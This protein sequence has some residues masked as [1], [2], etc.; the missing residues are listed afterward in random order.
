MIKKEL[1]NQ[2]TGNKPGLSKKAT[3]LPDK[4]KVISLKDIAAKK[5]NLLPADK[6]EQTVLLL[7]E[8]MAEAL[9]QGYVVDH[10]G[11]GE[12]T[13]QVRTLPGGKKDVKIVLTFYPEAKEQLLAHAGRS[14]ADDINMV[15]T[16]GTKLKQKILK[17]MKDNGHGSQPQP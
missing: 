10:A 13:L 17:I 1:P 5:Q 7:V 6:F 2:N 9:A 12:F 4:S 8:H 3:Q 11:L 15:L 16:P 14:F